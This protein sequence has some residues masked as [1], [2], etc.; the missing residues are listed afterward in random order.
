MKRFIAAGVLIGVSFAPVLAT[1]VPASAKHP[2]KSLSGALSGGTGYG[3]SSECSFLH[4]DFLFAVART[5]K[6]SA[7]IAID[8]CT[9]VDA[10]GNSVFPFTGHFIFFAGGGSLTGSVSGTTAHDLT[11]NVAV[12]L[13]LTVDSGTGPLLSKAGTMTISA[14]W[15][16]SVAPSP[17]PVTGT[18]TTALSG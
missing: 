5:K 10:G 14:T 18:L 7:A 9:Y 15:D 6:A 11:T 2:P 12:Q 4:Q 3:P 8:G 17:D 1:E 16:A 13:T